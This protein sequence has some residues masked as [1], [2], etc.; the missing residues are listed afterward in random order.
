MKDDPEPEQPEPTIQKATPI[1]SATLIAARE[2]RK[3]ARSET[4]PVKAPVED[5]D[6]SSGS[7]DGEVAA[8]LKLLAEVS[9]LEA[10]QGVELILAEKGGEES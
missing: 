1:P 5:T 8:V 7:S 2:K 3:R 4:P 6:S 9:T 10:S